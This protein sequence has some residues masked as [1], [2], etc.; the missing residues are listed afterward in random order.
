MVVVVRI[1][2]TDEERRALRRRMARMGLATR[3]EIASLVD[4]LI[5]HELDEAVGTRLRGDE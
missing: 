1:E 3:Y 4:M 5:R 2:V